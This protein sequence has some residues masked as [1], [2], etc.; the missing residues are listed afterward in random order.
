M[1]TLRPTPYSYEI[2]FDVIG[3]RR[4]A[5]DRW[6]AKNGMPW[7][8]HETVA[9]FDVWQNDKGLS[10]EVKFQFGFRTLDAWTR[11]V[12]SRCHVVA[13]EGLRRLVTGLEATLWERDGIRLDVTE[14]ADEQ[15]P[16]TA[17]CERR[18]SVTEEVR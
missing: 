8:T 1:T 5:Y 15:L 17:D 11:F 2:E 7:I 10:P 3:D 14:S 13:T 12:D 9:A 18:S 6:V 16:S 4:E